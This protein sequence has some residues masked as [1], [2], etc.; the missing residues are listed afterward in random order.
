MRHRSIATVIVAAVLTSL[1]TFVP[2]VPATA[3]PAT[4]HVQLDAR[5][6]RGE[7]WAFL[8]F[9]P[10]VVTI[11]QGD[12]LHASWAGT[13]TPHT[14]TLVPDADANAWRAANQGGDG[15]QDPTQY[16]WAFQVL[17]TSVGGDDGDVIV[18]PAAAAP[19]GPCGQPGT[20]CIFDGSGVVSSGFLPS[21]PG[22]QP[23]FDVEVDA[24]VGTYSFL[25]LVHPG[26]QETVNVV[27]AD[28]TS[29]QTPDEVNAARKAE[30]TH[31][32]RV[33]GA[34]AD[35]Q[36]QAVGAVTD[37]STTTYTINAGGFAHNVS[38][39]EY[40]DRGLSVSVGD[41][42]DVVGMPE[43]HTA[44][45]PY[46]SYRTVPLNTFACEAPGPDAPATSP[47]DCAAPSDFQAVFNPGAVAPSGGHRL[48]APNRFV[49][50]GILAPQQT[51]GFVARQPGT[52]RFIC[53][54]HGPEMA[55]EVTVSR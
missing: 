22:Q 16:P 40:V 31:S 51:Y 45:V 28:D 54:V 20:P 33:F 15:P 24:P 17:D 10:K 7:P 30:V 21:N 4:Y 2:V 9:Y 46:K 34:R 47:A 29:A 8:R 35:R 25:C 44:T 14:A 55:F 41:R 38:A 43:I 52:Y 19:S 50:S 27:A 32:K 37:G 3:A 49:N 1:A 42:I 48:T 13:D 23:Q 5:P 6:P 12:V 36:A 39:N 11:D 26:M 53:L 18:N